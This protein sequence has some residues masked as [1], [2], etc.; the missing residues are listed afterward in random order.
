[1][2]VGTWEASDFMSINQIQKLWAQYVP[3][4]K[5]VAQYNIVGTQA[6]LPVFLLMVKVF[7]W[8]RVRNSS[9]LEKLCLN[10]LLD[11][12]AWMVAPKNAAMS[13]VLWFSSCVS[14]V[15]LCT[16]QLDLKAI[17]FK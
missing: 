13:K 7:F 9:L 12:A 6:G 15:V 3:A 11:I 5:T 2:A 1:M 10:W 8:N 4:Q 16:I 17:F 14:F